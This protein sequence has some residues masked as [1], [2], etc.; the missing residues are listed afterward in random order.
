MSTA[1]NKGRTCKD[2]VWMPGSVPGALADRI[3]VCSILGSIPGSI[4]VP[5][6]GSIPDP[7]IGSIPDWTPCSILD[8]WFDSGCDSG[9]DARFVAWSG[10]WFRS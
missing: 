8:S 9:C 3:I 4:P 10:S 5:L 7:I 6:L 2:S 1:S